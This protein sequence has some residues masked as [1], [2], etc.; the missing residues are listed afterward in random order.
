L[1]REDRKEMIIRNYARILGRDPNENDLN[2]FLNTGI[3][4]DELL[5]KMVDSQEHA[6]L[7]KARQEV[8]TAKMKMTA[9]G[10]ELMTLRSKSL[11][12]DTII[13]NLNDTLIRKNEAIYEL[14]KKVKELEQKSAQSSTKEKKTTSTTPKEKYKGNFSDR[15]FKAFSDILE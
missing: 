2:Y 1:P 13:K 5:K 12:S 3:R 11:E 15:V 9:E 6:D 7:V 8:I 10:N 4:E 14:N